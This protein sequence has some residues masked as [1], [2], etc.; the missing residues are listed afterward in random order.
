M[1]AALHCNADVQLPYRMPITELTHVHSSIC[2][3]KCYERV[4]EAQMVDAAQLSQ[5]VQAGYACD[6]Q[7]QAQRAELQ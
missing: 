6:Y 5:D 4:S 7:K 2:G 3:N 1:H